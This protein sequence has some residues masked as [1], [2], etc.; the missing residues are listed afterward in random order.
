MKT[1]NIILACL[2]VV[3]GASFAREQKIDKQRVIS[4]LSLEDKAHFVIGTGMQGMNTNQA[5][6][7]ST[8]KLVPGAAGTTYPLDS[9]NIP[10]IVLADG[11]AGLRINPT[12]QGDTA[13][14][15][16][17]HFPIGTLLACTWNEALVENVG[18]AMGQEV[19]EYGVDVLLAPATNIHRNPLNGRNFEY[20]SE[21][22]LVAGKTAAAYIRGIQS[23]GVGTSLKHFACNNQET[24]RMSNDVRVSQRALRE[25]YLK[26]FEIAV[27]EAQPWT[28][29]SSYNRINGTYT[30]E[31]KE[32]LTTILRDEWGFKGTVMTDWNG[33]HDGAAQVW[34]GND[35]LQPGKPE[36]FKAIVDSV[37]NGSLKMSDLDRNV[38]RV[39]EL[40]EKTPGYHHYAF[41]NHPDLKA[42]ALVTRQSATEGMVLLK[43]KGALPLLQKNGKNSRIALYGCTSYDFIAGG[44]GSGNVNHAYVVSLKDGLLGA[45]YRIDETLNGLYTKYLADCQAAKK[46]KADSLMKIDPMKAFMTVFLPGDRPEEPL[47]DAASLEKEA[48]T[49]DV[50]VITLGRISGEFLDRKLSQYNLTEREHQ[51]IANV[52]QAFHKVGKKVIVLLN[53]GGVMETKSWKDLPDAIL[54][55]WQAGQEGGNSVADII[56]G[57]VSPSGKLTMT[58]PENL[59][60]D[61]SYHNFPVDKEPVIDFTNKGR[62][63]NNEKDVDYTDYDEDVFVGYRYFDSFGKNVSY[64]FGYGLSYTSF[65]YSNPAITKEG[66]GFSVSI[67]VKNVGKT[68]GKEVVELYVSAPD[69][70]KLD[71]PVK[72]LKAFAKTKSLKPG[73]QQ[74]LTMHVRTAD[75]A[76]FDAGKSEWRVDAGTYQFLFG[77]SSRDIRATLQTKVQ[78]MAIPVHDVL[79]PKVKLSLLTR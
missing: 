46:A 68:E 21:D 61:Y 35:M 5:V 1:K 51:L 25:I 78:Q 59:K 27:K 65:K 69:N 74:R 33:G 16:C 36:Q 73:E 71:K 70:K 11:P 13:T 22:P 45:G 77:A 48:S 72:E 32:L 63:G 60:D 76:S 8:Q 37:R 38:G 54:C 18:K 29:M 66:D 42:H 58:W 53:T 19:K 40:I 14:Y 6:V 15:Y 24:N 47:M 34:A 17:T 64:P 3:A 62:K 55:V 56:S 31:S 2:V 75:L 9:L 20:Y 79:K 44:T 7:G 43:N 41:S 4:R 12:R 50:A 57:K 67:D 23:N 10:A 52:C 26:P 30:S 28:I 39:L 49:A